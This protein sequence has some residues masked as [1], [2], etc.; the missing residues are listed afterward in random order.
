VVKRD[1]IVEPGAFYCLSEV[2]NGYWVGSYFC[3]REGNAKLHAYSLI[4]LYWV[5]RLKGH[6]DDI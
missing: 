1:K 6:S 3:L 4:A 2:A 5:V